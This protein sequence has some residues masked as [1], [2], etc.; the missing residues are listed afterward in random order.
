M[1][2][3]LFTDAIATAWEELTPPSYSPFGDVSH[4]YKRVEIL[5]HGSSAHRNFIFEDP[6]GGEMKDQSASRYGQDITFIA[7][8]SLNIPARSTRRLLIPYREIQVL[9][10]AVVGIRIARVQVPQVLGW[11][12]EPVIVE[13]S[14]GVDLVI[15]IGCRTKESN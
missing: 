6:E 12:T 2:L 3:I 5:G 15:T 4:P 14:F 10:P 11:K 13:G 8:M 1:P 7:R 9:R